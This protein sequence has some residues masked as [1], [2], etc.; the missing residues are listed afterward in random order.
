MTLELDRRSLIQ[1]A[2]FGFGALA[3]PG[4]AAALLAARG[5][6]HDVASGEPRQHSVLLW[7]RYVPPRGDSARIGWQVSQSPS[8]SRVVAQ[9]EAVAEGEHDFTVKIVAD[10]LAPGRWYY[11]RFRDR[12]SRV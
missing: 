7:T 3:L 11:Y 8:F 1:A 10:G 9:G 5:F 4:N 6:T 12:Q 2:S